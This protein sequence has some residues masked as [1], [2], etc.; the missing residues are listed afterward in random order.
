MGRRKVSRRYS[1]HVSGDFDG[2]RRIGDCLQSNH[3]GKSRLEDSG[4]RSSTPRKDLRS[5]SHRKSSTDTNEAR[6]KMGKSRKPPRYPLIARKQIKKPSRNVTKDSQKNSSKGNCFR[7]CVASGGRAT[8]ALSQRSGSTERGS[9]SL[10]LRIPKSTLIAENRDGVQ[11]IRGGDHSTPKNISNT[12]NFSSQLNDTKRPR[13]RERSSCA[14]TRA[15]AVPVRSMHFRSKPRKLPLPRQI[16]QRGSSPQSTDTNSANAIVSNHSETN[17]SNPSRFDQVEMSRVSAR[18]SASALISEH[19]ERVRELNVAPL[20]QSD[21]SHTVP[22][23][24]A[25]TSNKEKKSKR[26]TSGTRSHAQSK[27]TSTNV[28][29]ATSEFIYNN[30]VK[31]DSMKSWRAGNCFVSLNLAK[32]IH[33]KELLNSVDSGEVQRKK[34]R[35]SKSIPDLK[36]RKNRGRLREWAKYKVERLIPLSWRSRPDLYSKIK[37]LERKLGI[38]NTMADAESDRFGRGDIVVPECS[39]SSNDDAIF[40]EDAKGDDSESHL[41]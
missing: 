7:D 21:V 31:K 30:E 9:I 15:A 41:K 36:S 29:S 17:T 27:V 26:K 10:V 39:L 40:P 13:S 20:H 18:N 11:E 19:N 4:T 23:T 8:S 16:S 22:R 37:R 35:K 25:A 1:D 14:Q 34:R 38:K 32:S 6:L 5:I 28:K 33:E 2:A 24:A 12:R 3:G